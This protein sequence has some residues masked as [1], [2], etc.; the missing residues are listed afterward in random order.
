MRSLTIFDSPAVRSP[1]AAAIP[2]A[3]DSEQFRS[4]PKTSP[5]LCARFKLLEIVRASRCR[6]VPL[7]RVTRHMPETPYMRR[8]DFLALLTAAAAWPRGAR[9][10][11]PGKTYRLGPL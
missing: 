4:A 11:Q 6:P 10:Q 2:A 5:A 9:A 8:R 7:L 1:Q 3:I